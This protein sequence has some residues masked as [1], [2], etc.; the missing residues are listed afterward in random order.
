MAETNLTPS[1]GYFNR[2]YGG[3]GFSGNRPPRDIV[4]YELQRDNRQS[5][6]DFVQRY[7]KGFGRGLPSDPP[8][9]GYTPQQ[10]G[11]SG[12]ISNQFNPTINVQGGT[13][14]Q[15]TQAAGGDIK[16]SPQSTTASTTS[17]VTGSTNEQIVGGEKEKEKEKEKEIEKEKDKTPV[18]TQVDQFIAATK[19]GSAKT[20][21]EQPNY[22][23][24]YYDSAAQK[25][26][27]QAATLFTGNKTESGADEMIS[28]STFKGGGG[29]VTAESLG[30]EKDAGLNFV[31][32]SY[33][34]I[35]GR[36]PDKEGYDYFTSE[37]N[38]GSLTPES[39]IATLQGSPEAKARSD[40]DQGGTK[41]LYQEVDDY[42]AGGGQGG[43]PGSSAYVKDGDAPSVDT[44]EYIKPTPVATT[45]TQTGGGNNDAGVTVTGSNASSAADNW[46][47]DF[48][49]TTGIN[50]GNLDAE[51]K[52]YW[53]GE[54]AK[55]GKDKVK[56]IIKGTA[57][58]EG[59]LA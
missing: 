30:K 34:D 37:L 19:A 22:E 33:Q 48:Y 32:Q 43:T 13:Q 3:P 20:A 36:A 8:V 25:A 11:A 28:G 12:N 49:T 15:Q 39:F 2:P 45:M 51:A 27:Q 35:F 16:D 21:S 14:T 24:P 41:L 7:P 59:T 57:R 1:A 56:D 47:Q 38:T 5:A 23:S 52:T 9:F 10:Q 29:A 4:D 55:L 50:S 42:L 40:S 53:E 18:T 6:F 54:A 26:T 46:L 31:Q 44:T 17:T 58:A